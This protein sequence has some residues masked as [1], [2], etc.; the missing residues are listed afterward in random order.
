M[1]LSILVYTVLSVSVFLTFGGKTAQNFLLNDYH[2]DPF[3]C[4]GCIGFAIAVVVT[5]PLF[6]HAMRKN[7]NEVYTLFVINTVICNLAQTTLIPL[8]SV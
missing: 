3:V 6:I 7:I 2:G 5:I 1:C 4:I 8:A